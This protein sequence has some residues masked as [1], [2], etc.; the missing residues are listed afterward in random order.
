M[1]AEYFYQQLVWAEYRRANPLREAYWNLHLL[2]TVVGGLLFYAI[3]QGRLGAKITLLLLYLGY[4]YLTTALRHSLLAGIPLT[5]F[6]AHNLPLL[7]KHSLVV[8]ALVLLVHKK[9]ANQ[10]PAASKS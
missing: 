3:R 5:N 10:E 4:V 8:G 7:L 9:R 1:W 6:H 2:L